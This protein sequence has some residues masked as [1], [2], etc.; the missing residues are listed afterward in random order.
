MADKKM[1]NRG[2]YSITNW[3]DKVRCLM[4][5]NKRTSPS[6]EELVNSSIE[7]LNFYHPWDGYIKAELLAVPELKEIIQKTDHYTSCVA[8]VQIMGKIEINME[9]WH[10][11]N[12]YMGP[13]GENL[14]FL[15]RRSVSSVLKNKG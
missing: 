4:R 7:S 10:S 6:F 13:F 3:P 14:S 2:E 5:L 8:M 15:V 9:R 1:R 11:L 12:G